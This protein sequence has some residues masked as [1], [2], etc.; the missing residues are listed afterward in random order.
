MSF[1]EKLKSYEPLPFTVAKL[2]EAPLQNIDAP[3]VIVLGGRGVGMC[4]ALTAALFVDSL[5]SMR[6]LC[7]L[8]D[9]CGD[10]AASI[11]KD[12]AAVAAALAALLAKGGAL[13]RVDQHLAASNERTEAARQELRIA[14]GEVVVH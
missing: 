14:R 5:E 10:V 13:H 12:P 11:E 9:V 4:D 1:D 8:R 3:R 7:A 2:G 6:M